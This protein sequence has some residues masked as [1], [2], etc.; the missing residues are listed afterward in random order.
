MKTSTR[1]GLVALVAAIAFLYVFRF[2]IGPFRGTPHTQDSRTLDSKK[3]SPEKRSEQTG[4]FARLMD[5]SRRS[6][7]TS[8]SYTLNHSNVMVSTFIDRGPMEKLIGSDDYES[9]AKR[10]FE[11]NVR[12]EPGLQ[13]VKEIIESEKPGSNRVYSAVRMVYEL[14]SETM[15]S[16][17]SRINLEN[18]YNLK[19]SK[20]GQEPSIS[21]D[22]KAR[23][24]QSEIDEMNAQ[25]L[26]L[27]QDARLNAER[28]R[29]NMVIL[30]GELEQ[31][32]V[33]RF[34]YL[35]PRMVAGPLRPEK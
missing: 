32:T 15:E 23:R 1:R 30:V 19:I 25:F 9:L 29:R 2:Y 8:N 6:L 14:R 7:E 18:E 22:E 10:D 35:E 3:T 21:E 27:D 26:S 28:F 4:G 34:Y 33:E 31:A 5:A 17:R 13:R 16:R 11:D 24:M 20:I 12:F